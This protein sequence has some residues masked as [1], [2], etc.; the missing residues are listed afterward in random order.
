M[1]KKNERPLIF[2]TNDDGISAKGIHEL[3][4]FLSPLGDIICIAPDGPRS[5]QSMALT[6]TQPLRFTR[7]EDYKGAEMWSVNGTPVDC[8]KLGMHTRLGQCPLFRHYGS[9]DG[10]MR[11]RDSLGGLLPYEP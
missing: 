4:D 3:I 2:V 1:N 6:I 8:V 5:A 11:P 7:H 9:R 10:R